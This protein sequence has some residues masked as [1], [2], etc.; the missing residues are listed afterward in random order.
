MTAR[1]GPRSA[2]RDRMVALFLLGLLLFNPPL[3]RLFG[4]EGDVFG[5]PMLYVYI[6]GAWAAVI[7]LAALA[8]ER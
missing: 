3:L 7:A 1:R 6:L 4:M 8:A 5:L 2:R